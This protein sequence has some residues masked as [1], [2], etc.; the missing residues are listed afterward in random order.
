MNNQFLARLEKLTSN[1]P[2]VIDLSLN[3]V[4]KLLN[5]LDNPHLKL[6]P[7]IHVAGTN[8]K[9]STI[10]F[11][12]NSLK[13]AGKNVHV[14]TSPHLIEVTERIIIANK[15]ISYNKLFKALDYCEKVNGG[16][17]ITQFE[18]LT[19][20]AFYLMSKTKADVALIETGLGGRLD[21]TNVIQ[22]PIITIITSISMDHS[23]FL[24]NNLISIA[25]EKA[26]II[27]KNIPCISAPQTK[28]VEKE[29]IKKCK[30]KQAELIVCSKDSFL[31]I[32]NIG[33]KINLPTSKKYLFS[34]PS[35]EGPHQIINAALAITALI[36]ISE[37]NI[38]LKD[39]NNGIIS[40][41]WPGRLEKINESIIKKHSILT[42]DIWLDGGH[43]IAGAEAIK[44]W[45]LNKGIKNIILVCGFLKNKEARDILLILKKHIQYIILVPLNNKNS[46]TVKELT[47][48][49][50][51]LNIKYYTRR[52]IKEAI[53]SNLILKSSK[54]LIFGSLYLIGD[55]L[56]L[57]NN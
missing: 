43:N 26:G 46:Y 53:T 54:V 17:A 21:A 19:C 41:H 27:K 11:M 31:S 2:K 15:Q 12:Y 20:I 35:L 40:T 52:S 9:G 50:K 22:K 48:I 55:A 37:L 7:I 49:S 33:F 24:G 4:N 57:E 51:N 36:K 38:S 6:P 14:Y 5:K 1:Y 3:R 45:I 32:N 34:Q 44:N 10:A 28:E 16:E 8:G 42:K 25:K 18:L 13:C 39:M 23:D 30:A 29:L 47:I 56:K